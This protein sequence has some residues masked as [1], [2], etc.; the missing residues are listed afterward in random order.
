MDRKGVTMHYC[1]V[2]YLILLL[3]PLLF[4]DEGLPKHNVDPGIVS[5]TIIA[6]AGGRLENA[7][8]FEQTGEQFY[9]ASTPPEGSG[10]FI[11]E[12]IF[13]VAPDGTFQ[14]IIFDQAGLAYENRVNEGEIILTGG[15]GILFADGKLRFEFFIANEGDPHCCPTA[16]KISGTYKMVGSKQFHPRSKKYS[17]TYRLVADT[18]RRDPISSGELAAYGP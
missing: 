2:F 16:G 11:T 8:K 7:I 6:E 4:A 9:Y 18:Y 10:G 3:V 5:K 1:Q 15:A 14:P 17:C 13:W 12:T